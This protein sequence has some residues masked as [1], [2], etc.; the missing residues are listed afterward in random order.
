M[1]EPPSFGPDADPRLPPLEPGEVVWCVVPAPDALYVGTD[2]RLLRVDDGGSRAWPYEAI[3]SVDAVGQSGEFI[4]GMR[5]GSDRIAIA[6]PDGPEREQSLQAMTI[7]NLLVALTRA[8]RG[9]GVRQ[10][11]GLPHAAAVR[12]Q[13]AGRRPPDRGSGPGE[14]PQ[15][16]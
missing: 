14:R 4:I 3:E 11:A 5:E 10:A 8:S 12:R 1:D 6:V 13:A 15:P 2:R 16:R 7:V 9:A